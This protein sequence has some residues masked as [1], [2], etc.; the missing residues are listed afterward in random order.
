MHDF[1][2]NGETYQI[3][4]LDPMTQF[5]VMRRIAPV[6]ASI[7]GG[8]KDGI[9]GLTLAISRLSDED[10]EYVISRCLADCRRQSGDN[11]AKIYVSGRLMFDD[12][13]MGGLVSLTLETLK[14]SISG[15]MGALGDMFGAKQADEA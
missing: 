12:I 13:G 14:G 1:E 8:N 15:A 5:H 10:V 6:L 3:A 2:F 7:G 11:W 4:K 9:M